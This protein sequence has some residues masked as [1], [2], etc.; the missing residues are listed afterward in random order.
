MVKFNLHKHLECPTKSKLTIL[1]LCHRGIVMH[2]CLELA[3]GI[4]RHIA[5]IWVPTYESV[6]M[7]YNL[8]LTH[9]TRVRSTMNIHMGTEPPN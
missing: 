9:W 7:N 6:Q 5:G 3:A 2:I 8:D 1:S 4:E